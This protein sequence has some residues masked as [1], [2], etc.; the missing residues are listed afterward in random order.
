MRL[1]TL[2]LAAV[3]VLAQD[4]EWKPLFDGKELGAW[5]PT[6]FK[7]QG[8]VAVED[9]AIVIH[10]GAPLTGINYTGPMPQARYEVRF[11]ARK[12]RGGDFFA[13]LTLPFGPKAF[14]WVNGGWGGD[15]VGISSIDG[16]DASD[17]ETR[18]YF[19][20]E[21]S[22][23]YRFRIAVSPDRLTA[24]IDDQQVIN[25][26][27]AGRAISMRPGAAELSA[28]FGFSSYNTT[29]AIRNIELRDLRR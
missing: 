12:L 5:R 18:T 3:T 27:V 1:A 17:N 16:W 15:I 7:G 25:V 23:W 2:M 19:E 22:R 26:A 14:T 11:E 9:G 28:P 4:A 20:F 8:K 24:W 21:P 6:A 10:A 13:S 29:G